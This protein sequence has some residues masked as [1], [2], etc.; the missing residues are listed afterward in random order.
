[1]AGRGRR[2]AFWPRWRGLIPR[3]DRELA[4]VRYLR[5]EN[6]R[7]GSRLDSTVVVTVYSG[8]RQSW[9]G[10]AYKVRELACRKAVIVQVG[11]SRS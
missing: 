4:R 6:S 3:R 11:E 7:A 9:Q 1:M 2:L 10:L 8:P 5:R